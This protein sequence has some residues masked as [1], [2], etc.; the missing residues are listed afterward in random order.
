MLA[1]ARARLAAGRL[2]LHE[3]LGALSVQWLEGDEL[4]AV[5]PTGQALINVNTP[6]E[7]GA[8]RSKRSAQ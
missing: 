3:L 6:A 7:L 5:D 2:A 1:E 8:F 4:A